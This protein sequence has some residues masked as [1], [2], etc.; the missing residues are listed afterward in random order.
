MAEVLNYQNY[1]DEQLD[2]LILQL[3]SI[4]NN[5][6]IEL[7]RKKEVIYESKIYKDFCQTNSD[8]ILYINN[9]I[10]DFLTYKED[11]MPISYPKSI[12]IKDPTKNDIYSHIN[13]T[14]G[15]NG[16]LTRLEKCNIITEKMISYLNK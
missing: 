11:K 15:I 9:A 6:K 12:Y 2:T 16:E 14:L 8:L 13:I 10:T 3:K 7:I 4:R 1:T 5:R